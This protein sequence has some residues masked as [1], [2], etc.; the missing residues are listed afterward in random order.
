MKH[1]CPDYFLLG[2]AFLICVI[3]ALTVGISYA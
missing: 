3:A 2:C 1:D